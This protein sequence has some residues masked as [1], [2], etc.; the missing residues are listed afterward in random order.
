MAKVRIL[1]SNV[2]ADPKALAAALVAATDLEAPEA[3]A[4]VHTFSRPT[5]IEGP[6]M[7][8]NRLRAI[9]RVLADHGF[10]VAFDA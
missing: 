1:R 4:L 5:Q 2:V 7:H 6:S 3:E 8:A 9:A 10:E